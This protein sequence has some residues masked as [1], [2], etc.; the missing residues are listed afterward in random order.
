VFLWTCQVAGWR[1]HPF[2]ELLAGWP[3][4]WEAEDIRRVVHN[5]VGEDGW[6]LL[7]LRTVP[8]VLGLDPQDVFYDVGLEELYQRDLT[9]AEAVEFEPE[10]RKLEDDETAP[11]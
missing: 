7:R 3:G 10:H 8:I 6:A 2:E 9:A 4:S 11:T 5:T 1:S